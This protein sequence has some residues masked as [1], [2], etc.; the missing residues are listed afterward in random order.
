MNDFEAYDPGA[1]FDDTH[2]LITRAKRSRKA[3]VQ[4]AVDVVRS[5]LAGVLIG[6]SALGFTMAT[7]HAA[8]TVVHSERNIAQSKR[9]LS[10][11]YWQGLRSALSRAPD[12]PD[13]ADD[14]VE[15]VL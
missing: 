11:A 1:W 3:P 4:K 12:V 15:P 7:A 14:D 8:P 2:V 10:G 5:A 9:G 6:A 13:Y